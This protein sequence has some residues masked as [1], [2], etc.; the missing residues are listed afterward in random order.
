M[1]NYSWCCN[2]EITIDLACSECNQSLKQYKK[3][4]NYVRV[5]DRKTRLNQYVNTSVTELDQNSR[6]YRRLV[7]KGK[8][9]K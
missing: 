2:A 3:I 6:T 4:N 1:N 8:I 5:I 9:N 7:K